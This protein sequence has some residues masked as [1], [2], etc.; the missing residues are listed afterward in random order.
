[1]STITWDGVGERLYETGVSKGVLYQSDGI[2]VPWN[3][4]TSVQE[5]SS[6]QVDSLH[7]DGTKY[8]DV[9]T[10]GDFSASLKAFTYPDEFLAYEGTLTEQDGFYIAS[11][12]K[13]QFGLSYQTLI[14][15]DVSGIGQHYKIHILY[16]LT[17]IP[18]SKVYETLSLD[19]QPTEFEWSI[20]SVPERLDNYRPT[21]H[22]IFDSRHIDPHLLSDIEDI[23]YGDGTTPAM[24][25]S[26]KGLVSFVRKWDRFV[27]VDNGDGT[28]TATSREEGQIIMINDTTFQI[29]A[30]TAVY[31]SSD[32]YEL[33]SSDKNE[34]DL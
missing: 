17:A 29:T 4:L 33:S 13:A 24:L 31:I 32:T 1:M 18:S 15:D 5:S 11:Q 10:L 28:W 22:V 16:N 9:V 20:T 21:S 12:P 30:D 8:E 26:L 25:P 34:E 6:D 23:L 2:G 19:S 27:V 7:F 3:G 14:G